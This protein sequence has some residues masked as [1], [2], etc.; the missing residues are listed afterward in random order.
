MFKVEHDYTNKYHDDGMTIQKAYD[1]AGDWYDKLPPTRVIPWKDH[2]I[3]SDHHL[4]GGTK[5][6]WGDLLFQ[7]WTKNGIKEFVYV[8]PRQGFAAIAMTILANKYGAKITL[9]MPSSKRASD[10]QL[11]AIQL[12]AKPIFHRIAAMPNLNRIALA[13]ADQTPDAAFIPFGLDHPLVV[14]AGVVSTLQLSK[15]PYKDFG[16]GHAASVVST[17][18]LTRTLQI[19]WPY[20]CWHGVAV[21]RNMHDGECGMARMESYPKP[22]TSPASATPAN[23]ELPDTVASERC[24]DLKGLEWVEANGDLG[25]FLFWNVAGNARKPFIEPSTVDSYRDW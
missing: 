22:F 11:L 15:D 12:G 21:A 24:Y 10:H 20:L 25:P 18:V 7:E 13:Y 9:F 4:D 1:L 17:G 23:L 16:L 3:L 2:I 8:A 5:M 19:A 6:R 14:A